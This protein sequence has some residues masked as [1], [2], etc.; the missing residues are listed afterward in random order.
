VVGILDVAVISSDCLR[1]HTARDRPF[2][3]SDDVPGLQD[4]NS[5]GSCIVLVGGSGGTSERMARC[6]ESQFQL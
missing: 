2:T 4:G 3:G 5:D 1:A 6:P